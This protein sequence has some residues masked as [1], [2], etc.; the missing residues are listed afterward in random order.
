MSRLLALYPRAWRARYGEEFAELLESR[1]PTPRD[2]L[3][4]VIGAIDARINPQ[5]SGADDRERSVGGDRAA[6]VTAV[7]TG[8]LLTI[9]GVIGA[10]SMV[11]WDSG[12]EPRTPAE[13]INLAWMSG[14]L[15]AFLAPVAF[16]IVIVRYQRVLG[17]AG[18][19]GALLTPAGLIMSALGM[20]MVALLALGAGVI[21]FSWRANG[22][23]LSAPVALGF[24]AGTLLNVAGF[25][26][27]AAGG[28]QD[29]NV[30][31]S[32][33]ALGPS[34]ILF[35]IGLRQPQGLPDPESTPEPS[36]AGA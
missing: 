12:L 21:L 3:D 24:A 16:G 34:W 6:R 5:I 7:V 28:G 30:L 23:I 4:I 22:R 31:M 32:L 9:W 14:M 17:P 19:I 27:F 29:V 25:M 11:P 33:V 1:P 8:V 15:G 20:G 26:V 2:R 18:V 10:T 35:G 13:L 36:L